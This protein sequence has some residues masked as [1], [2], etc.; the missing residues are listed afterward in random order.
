MIG[1]APAVC[2]DGGMPKVG[3]AV[4]GVVAVCVVALA[5]GCTADGNPP[6]PV[7]SA[8]PADVAAVRAA[9]LQ[10]ADIG[11]A[12]TVPKDPPAAGTLVGLCGGD[13]AGPPKPGTPTAVVSPLVDEGDQG[14]QTLN[15]TALVYA[16]SAAATSGLNTLRGVANAC[17]PSVSVPEK[18][19]ERQEP[20]YTETVST[21]PLNQGEW[22]GFVV[23]R[24]KQYDA[25]NPATADTAVAVLG[26]RNVVLVD[27]YA[28]FRLG[29]ASAGPQFTQ[30]WQNLVGTVLKRLDA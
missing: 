13:T 5:A 29:T 19:G 1:A 4:R 8:P 25:K 6:S 14:A 12:W 15:Q 11:P 7:P 16:D 20:A 30:D 23:T 24:H 22:A 9:L 21:A 26:R 17:P 27:A 10:A 3:K 18:T 2:Q 28:I